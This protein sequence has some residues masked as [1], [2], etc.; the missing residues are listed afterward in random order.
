MNVTVISGRLGRDSETK[1]INAS[2]VTRFTVAVSEKF[3]DKSG[4]WQEKTHWVNCFKWGYCPELKKGSLVEV[5][6]SLDVR[7]YEKDG[8]KITVTEVK[9]D[10]IKVLIK[11]KGEESNT[12]S[13]IPF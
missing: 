10:Q 9:A 3:K 1:D 2:K 5:K 7:Q 4:D 8:N 13:E 12:Q 11:P 6:G